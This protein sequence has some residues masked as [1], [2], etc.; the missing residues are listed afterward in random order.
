MYART[1]ERARL[2][3]SRGGDVVAVDGD[4][5]VGLLAGWVDPADAD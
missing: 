3:G 2:S 5:E 4:V 1:V